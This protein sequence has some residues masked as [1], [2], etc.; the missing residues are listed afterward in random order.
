VSLYLVFIA[1]LRALRRNRLRAV[2]TMLGIMIG[3]AAVICTVALGEG[4]A[5]QIHQ[6]LLNLGDNFVWVENGSRTV[7]GARTA[8]GS[9]QR[10]L[11]EDL[12]AITNEVAEIKACSAQVDARSQVLVGG[13]N[14]ST[15][16]R[17]VSANYAQ[18]RRWTVVAGTFF[19]EAD[20]EQRSKVAVLGRT[21]AAMLF[22]EDDPLDQIIRI[23]S[24]PFKVVGVLNKK[25]SS[26]TGQDQDDFVLLP[27]TT[28]QRNLK[29]TLY[30]DDILC[31][32]KSEA[33]I[34]SARDHITDLLRYRHRILDGQPDDFNLPAPDESIK[35]REDAARTMGLMLGSI[36]AI[37]LVVGGVGVMNIMLVSVTERT[38]EIGLR[39]AIGGR[40][41]D[42]HRQF[43]AEAIL[44]SLTGGAVGI[45][46]GIA[47]SR[48][49]VD[50]LGWPSMVSV[51][52]I[53]MATAFSSA[54]G[55]VFGYYPARRA[56]QLDPIEALR[57][58]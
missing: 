58:E 33:D 26:T 29:G 11:P 46:F 14:W 9:V 51:N 15:T 45:V 7:S 35:T 27:Y 17:G 10:L 43:I 3:I 16:Y 44:L 23:G 31:S 53:V 48:V 21:V 13:H 42:V 8:I 49:L 37:S 12:D 24:Q 2:L 54:T 4:S 20:V 40:E 19:D 47:A 25:G 55:L 39:L 22:V 18:I 32:A 5:A 38:R 41:R 52:A 57:F 50:A 30:L 6:D 56:S 1:A 36:A 34:P 28:A